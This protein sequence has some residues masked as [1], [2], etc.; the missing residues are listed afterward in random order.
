MTEKKNWGGSRTG[1]GRP[2]KET[3]GNSFADPLEFLKAVWK[4]ELEANAGQIRAA[5]AALPFLHKKLG[6]GGK[7]AQKQEAAS[8]VA[9]RFSAGAPPKLVVNGG[10][11]I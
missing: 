11:Q 10:K 8:Q 5:Q 3:E 6:E 7:K 2:K 1:A 9:G 4:G